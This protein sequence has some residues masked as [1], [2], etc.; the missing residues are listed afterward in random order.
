M[1]NWGISRSL[2][3]FSALLKHFVIFVATIFVVFV[4]L[5]SGP[6]CRDT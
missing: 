1:G 6:T 5:L 3:R 2:I 4:A